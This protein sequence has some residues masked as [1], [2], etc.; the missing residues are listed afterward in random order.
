MSFWQL[1]VYVVEAAALIM[2][3]THL[4]AFIWHD[5]A[6]LFGRKK[7]ADEQIGKENAPDKKG[8]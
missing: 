1:S 5:T 7:K 8:R 3:V 6:R 4:V 2:L